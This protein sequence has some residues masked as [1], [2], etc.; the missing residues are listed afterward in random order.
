V[1]TAPERREGWRDLA[2][3]LYSHANWVS[4]YSACTEALNI[5]HGTN[6]YLDMTDVWGPQLH[7]LAAISAW[8]LGLKMESESHAQAAVNLDPQD[9]RL[10]AN[11][12]AIQHSLGKTS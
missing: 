3:Y 9:H 12:T 6:S 10:V 1:A 8:N 2:L 4:C 5:T 11:L 7:D